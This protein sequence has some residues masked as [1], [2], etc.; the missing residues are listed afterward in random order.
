MANHTM[1]GFHM[2]GLGFAEA[3]LQNCRASLLLYRQ[4]SEPSWNVETCWNTVSFWISYSV[5]Q[6]STSQHSKCFVKHMQ[7]SKFR[8]RFLRSWDSSR[9][10]PASRN[11]KCIAIT[12]PSDSLAHFCR[13]LVYAVYAKNSSSWLN[14]MCSWQDS[15]ASSFTRSLSRLLP[16]RLHLSEK[17][18][19]LL[20]PNL[21][22]WSRWSKS[23]CLSVGVFYLLHLLGDEYRKNS[24]DSAFTSK[25]CTQKQSWGKAV[26]TWGLANVSFCILQPLRQ[27][28]LF[29][30]SLCG[31]L[32]TSKTGSLSAEHTRNPNHMQSWK[33]TQG[34]TADCFTAWSTAYIRLSW[35]LWRLCLWILGFCRRC[36][37]TRWMS[38]VEVKKLAVLT[39][40]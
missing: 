27:V 16:Y 39:G 15:H 8:L 14:R 33:N 19:E 17:V 2:H 32:S 3:W 22:E 38:H 24:W 18:V 5:L 35:I 21:E 13:K 26:C 30:S 40:L 7:N 10:T 9:S 34:R 25:P 29:W 11:C 37:G 1:S 31:N 4:P 23:A 6:S 12:K 36:V 20:P 28:P